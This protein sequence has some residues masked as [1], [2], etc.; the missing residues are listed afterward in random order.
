MSKNLKVLI[1]NADKSKYLLKNLAQR[2]FSTTASKLNNLKYEV[3][4]NYN[5]N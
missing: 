4:V 2:S 3:K 5:Y 1:L